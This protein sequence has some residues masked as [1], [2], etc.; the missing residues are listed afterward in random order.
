MIQIKKFKSLHI[1]VIT[2]YP[3]YLNELY[4]Y[5]TA[6]VNN[7]YFTPKYKSGF[8]DGKICMVDKFQNTLPYGL[9]PDLLRFH[10]KFFPEIKIE[11]DDDVKVIFK[12]P[13]IDINY[14]LRLQPYYYQKDCIEA[15]LKFSKG[16][17]VSATAS[18]KSLVISYIIKILSENCI[19]NNHIIVVPTVNLVEQ[20][21]SDMIEY[22]I[23]EVLIG[24]V[25]EAY[26]EFH[27]PIVISTWQTLSN[28]LK[29]LKN[30]DCIIFDECHQ[31]KA[32]ELKKIA[33]KCENAFYRIGFTGT[34]Q[35]DKLEL[36]NI[37]SFLGPVLREYKSGQLAEEGY[38]SRCN[39]EAI[40]IK[41][42]N[43]PKGEY[44]DIKDAIFS[45]PMRLKIIKNIL[46]EA[47]HNILAL[48]GKVEREGELLKNYLISPQNGQEKEIIF[49]Y[50]KTPPE[51]REFWRK[52]C[53]KRKNIIIIATYGIF[54]LGVNIPSL[55]YIVL[56]SPFKS[57][58][59]VLQ[60][61]GRALRKHSD[62]IDGATIYDIIDDCKYF[63][64]HG[65]KRL[66]Y[67]ATEGFAINER[68]VDN[69]SILLNES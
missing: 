2:D 18:G 13:E 6:Y 32:V 35:D 27:K 30:Y 63:D 47:D 26:K 17:V 34:L 49:L 51:E 20:F 48:V 19:T 43:E 21:R 67:Y 57:K 55:K 36:W 69:V 39:I 8:W 7:Y 12:G 15:A 5:F 37:K 38:I 9:L 52:E 68:T 60:S 28:N 3:D 58:I 45:N 29:Y 33:E 53:E 44:N 41:Y 40:T 62:K 25:Y 65:E 66:R 31:V 50:G 42:V 14:S 24:R 54:Q 64:E 4:K 46:M 11:L 23:P 22:N 16:L 59:R 56:A 1:Q 10:K 61:V